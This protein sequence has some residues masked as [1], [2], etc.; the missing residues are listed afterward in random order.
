MPGSLRY[1]HFV[2]V[3]IAAKSATVVIQSAADAVPSR[4]VVIEQ[5]PEGLARLHRILGQGQAEPSAT[6]VVLEATG[7]SWI[8]R[9]TTL[10]HA[11]Y[12]VSVINPAQAH[13]F[14]KA[15]LRRSKTD[16]IDATTLARLAATLQPEPWTPPPA[17][18]HELQQRLAQRDAWI[19]LRQQVRNQRH[20]LTQQPVIVAEVVARMDALIATLDAQITEIEAE[21]RPALASDAAWDAAAHRLESIKG[22]GL[23]TALWI[24]VTTLNFTMCPT[25]EAAAAYAGLA[26]RED[27]SGTSVRRRTCIGKTGNARLRT[28]LY[29]ATLSAA[30]SNPAIKTFYNRLRDAGKLQKVARCAAARKLLH[31]AWAVVVNERMWEPDDHQHHSALAQSAA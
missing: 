29:M 5:T 14:A 24:L 7:S 26:P 15:L 4:P 12:A 13:H 9:A 10:H 3:D 27:E 1:R 6:L 8:T 31:V 30:Q 18:Y 23:V 19:G 21:L 22:I 20:A 2:G 28:A 17:V 16:A 25:P 11:G